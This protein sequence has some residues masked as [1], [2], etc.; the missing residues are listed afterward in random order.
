[1]VGATGTKSA[2]APA[3]GTKKAPDGAKK[4]N[5]KQPK[6]LAQVVAADANEIKSAGVLLVQPVWL[7]DPEE[8]QWNVLMIRR[9]GRKE[10]ELP[11]GRVEYGETV[12]ETARRELLEETGWNL[13]N[14]SYHDMFWFE[15]TNY[16]VMGGGRGKRVDWWIA[17]GRDA[18]YTASK[19]ERE[20]DEQYVFF[21]CPF[22]FVVFFFLI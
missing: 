20:T 11:K 21:H 22:L 15:T 16:K 1:M 19:K 5:T 17:D 9:C 4:T 2:S 7:S 8:N 18:R 10:W 3:A 13:S 14:R 12:K 6:T